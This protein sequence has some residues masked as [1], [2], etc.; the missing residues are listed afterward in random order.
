VPDPVETSA[1]ADEPEAPAP[2]DTAV[3][4]SPSD[5]SSDHAEDSAPGKRRGGWWSFGKN[6]S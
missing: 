5:T 3:A 6:G 4:P 1:S 2:V